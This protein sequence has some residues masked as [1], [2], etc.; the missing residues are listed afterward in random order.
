LPR[1]LGVYATDCDYGQ[2]DPADQSR[3]RS[4]AYRFVIGM[5][6]ARPDRPE[7]HKVGT[8]VLGRARGVNRM[9]R[10]A[11]DAVA[12]ETAGL[13]NRDVTLGQV[14]A[15]CT[16]REGDVTTRAHQHGD[17]GR[18]DELANLRLDFARAQPWCAELQDGGASIDGS[19][20]FYGACHNGHRRRDR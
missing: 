10:A 4:E 9:N 7:D 8:L 5:A 18:G 17:R 12:E 11:D 1:T 13:G 19:P 2:S 6:G 15:R 16:A 3:E 14:D 20:A